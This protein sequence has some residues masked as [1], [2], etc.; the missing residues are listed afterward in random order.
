MENIKERIE[1][2]CDSIKE[3]LVRKNGDYGDSAFQAP[4]L[5]P[6]V[7]PKTAILVRASDKIARL[8]N[9]LTTGKKPN[10]ETLED[11][12]MDLAGYCILYLAAPDQKQ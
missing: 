11:T 7:E 8:N 2:V 3:L 1:E 4:I 12:V 6:N 5:T 9:L 10:W